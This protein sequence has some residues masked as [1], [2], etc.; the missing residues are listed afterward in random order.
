M[1]SSIFSHL[2]CENTSRCIIK[3]SIKWSARKA[4]SLRKT[5]NENLTPVSDSPL[6]WI[7]SSAVFPV[8]CPISSQRQTAT[9]VVSHP[10]FS[11][12]LWLC[13]N[14]MLGN[15]WA[16]LILIAKPGQAGWYCNNIQWPYSLNRPNIIGLGNRPLFLS[17]VAVSGGSWQDLDLFCLVDMCCMGYN[18][19][20]LTGS[21]P[22]ETIRLPRLVVVRCSCFPSGG[23]ILT[24]VQNENQGRERLGTGIHFLWIGMTSGSIHSLCYRER[25]ASSLQCWVRVGSS[26]LLFSDL[27]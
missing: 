27:N 11:W 2:Q 9:L 6:P 13:T 19:T 4:A 1:P 15:T 21:V 7:E 26:G 20:V 12:C 22:E 14:R 8:T 5:Y 25:V 10:V 3:Q 18:V 16:C 17:T 23:E 24:C